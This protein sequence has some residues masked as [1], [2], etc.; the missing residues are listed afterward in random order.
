LK[1]SESQSILPKVFRDAHNKDN[2]VI[3]MEIGYP[4]VGRIYALNGDGWSS[5]ASTME[6]FWSALGAGASGLVL[7]LFLTKDAVLVCA[8]AANLL[9][10]CGVD[11]DIAELS[12]SE[13]QAYDAGKIF[14]STQLNGEGQATGVRGDDTPWQGMQQEYPLKNRKA[15]MHPTF[16]TV[17][18]VFARRTSITAVL[19]DDNYAET[20]TLIDSLLQMID[21][22]G[23]PTR[24]VITGLLDQLIQ[25][26]ARSPHARL[27]LD[28]SSSA[29][30]P[31]VIEQMNVLR[32]SGLQVSLQQL[33]DMAESERAEL[34]AATNDKN[35]GWRFVL[36]NMPWT[37]TAVAL[38]QIDALPCL[39]DGLVTRGV[40]PSVNAISPRSLIFDEKFAGNQLDVTRWSAGY[41]HINTET[42]ITV[43]D[44]LIIDIKEGT[45]YS[46]GAAIALL[47]IYGDFDA[48]VSFRVECPH[49]ATTFELAAI[50]I[51]PGYHHPGNTDL[52]T[53]NVNLTFDVHGAP[54]YASSERDQN[55]GF[56]CGWNNSYNLTKFGDNKAASKD[57]DWVASSSN[58]YNKYGRDVGDGSTGN[59]DGHLRL[60]RSGTIFNTYYRDKH[61]SEWVCSGSMLV[62]S[63]PQDV[64]I[65]LAAKHWHKIHPAPGNT[66]RFRNFAVR[67]Y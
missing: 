24:V 30:T 57:A 2:E 11:V 16:E 39:M 18:Q 55:D 21:R 3:M 52:N 47:P 31:G 32:C 9:S 35:I 1:N 23:L 4:V 10:S 8:P 45:V 59:L 65:R 53:R 14:R 62:Q 6:S 20:I 37:P 43:D 33:D 25:V 12:L 46:G 64:Y 15:L 54:P 29:L 50:A 22:Y 63:M 13:L 36:S 7:N 61:N 42:N 60:V 26:C 27:V 41:S 44:E 17:L 67:Q 51:D 56:R 19:P 66:V 28:V 40:L 58:M 34:I 49:Q 38:S 48:T 5:P